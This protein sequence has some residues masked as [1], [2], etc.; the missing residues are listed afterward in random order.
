ARPRFAAA[1]LVLVAESLADACLRANL[2]RRPGVVLVSAE[3]GADPPWELAEAVG[4]EH[5]AVLPRAMPWLVERFAE[6]AVRAAGGRVVAVLG[7]RGGP[8]ARLGRPG[9]AAGAR[10]A[11]RLRRRRPGGRRRGAAHRRAAT[12]RAL[13]G[14]GRPATARDFPGARPPA[15]RQPARRA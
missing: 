11:A 10:R 14:A 5:L 1:P 4:A 15:R 3:S 9:S 2:P 13:A 8:R 6:T 7:G 12:R